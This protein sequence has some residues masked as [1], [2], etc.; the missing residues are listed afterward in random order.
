[1][2]GPCDGMIFSGC[3][4]ML[5]LLILFKFP[6]ICSMKQKPEFPPNSNVSLWKVGRARPVNW[7]E[8]PTLRILVV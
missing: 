2:V 8:D 1:M 5:L 7:L 3:G 4:V 6:Q